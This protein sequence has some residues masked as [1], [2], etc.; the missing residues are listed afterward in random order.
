MTVQSDKPRLILDATFKILQHKRYYEITTDD[1]AKEAKIGKGTI[2]RYFKD[3]DEL[4]IKLASQILYRL[5]ELCRESVK[6][7]TNLRDKLIAVGNSCK[8]YLWE[9]P[10]IF[11]VV[12]EE[13]EI[14]MKC[15]DKTQICK[16]H[17]PFYKFLEEVLD[18]A[19]QLKELETEHDLFFL[20]TIFK[21]LMRGTLELCYFLP[22][23]PINI[24]QTVDFYI[25]G[26]KTKAKQGAKNV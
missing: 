14:F 22:D 5:T 9:N 10:A 7:K 12:N 2:Y 20:V 26:I 16:H 19:I 25:E 18:D 11:K 6:D 4:L 23:Q 15:L 17:R 24:E 21:S 3:K 8:S 1:I 13:Y